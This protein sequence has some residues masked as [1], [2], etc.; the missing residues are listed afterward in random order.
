MFRIITLKFKRMQRTTLQTNTGG[1]LRK[2]Q[3]SLHTALVKCKLERGSATGSE[4]R[5]KLLYSVGARVSLVRLFVGCKKLSVFI[6][7]DVML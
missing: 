7:H 3:D 1:I 4:R 6:K 5:F 2:L